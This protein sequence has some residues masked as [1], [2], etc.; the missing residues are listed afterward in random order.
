MDNKKKKKFKL[1]DTQREGRGVEKS[2]VYTKTDLKG[3]FIKYKIYFTRLLSVNL[4]M[5][6]GNFPLI[7]A[8]F[9]MSTLTRIIYFAPTSPSF[10]LLNG[11]FTH[12]TEI[13]SSNL[14]SIGLEGIQYQASAMTNTTYLLFALAALVIFTFG[15]VNAGTTYVLRNMVRGEPVFVFSDFF[16][17]IRRNWKQALPFGILDAILLVL[18]PFNLYFLFTSGEGTLNSIMLGITVAI[19]IL[20]FWMRFYIYVQMVTFDLS[21]YKILKN[22]LIFALLGF[23][24]NIM[25]TLGIVLLVGINLLLAVGFY[26]VLSSAAILFPLVLLFSNGAFM[27]MYASYFKIKEIMI[28]PY[29]ASAPAGENTEEPDADSAGLAES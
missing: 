18:I 23:K 10:S 12:Q 22:S 24:R 19:A 9:A 26:G 20:Y 8:A 6:I 29:E 7:F 11:I 16:Y 14:I 15:V 17:A 3:F 28:D 5:V 2:D 27:A 25:A 13:S 4:L 1:F 21:V